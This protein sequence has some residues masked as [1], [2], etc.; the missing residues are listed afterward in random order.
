MEVEL[1]FSFVL[2]LLLMSSVNEYRLGVDNKL[3]EEKLQGCQWMTTIKWMKKKKQGC[4]WM[5]TI[6]WM[7]KKYRNESL[8]VE[9]ISFTVIYH[10]EMIIII[11]VKWMKKEKRWM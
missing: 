5:T 4:E 6:R 8:R 3:D 9:V 1:R 10:R 2:F 7:K 11:G